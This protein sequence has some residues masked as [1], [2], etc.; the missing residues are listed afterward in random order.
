MAQICPAC[1]TSNA[2]AATTC[3]NCGAALPGLPSPRPP[4][5]RRPAPRRAPRGPAARRA[6]PHR[7]PSPKPPAAPTAQP[8]RRRA[9]APHGA[10]PRRAPARRRPPAA[11]GRDR[12]QRADQHRARPRRPAPLQHPALSGHLGRLRVLILLLT[13]GA[14]VWLGASNA[15]RIRPAAHADRAAGAVLTGTLVTVNTTKGTLQDRALRRRPGDKKHCGNFR[16]K[17]ASGYYDGKIFHRVEDW[18]VQGGATRAAAP[19]GGSGP[20]GW[21]WPHRRV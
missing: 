10:R 13:I 11:R 21:R 16:T 18:L 19:T 2:D 6:P 20:A 15:R 8:R 14:L 1:Q 4:R 3:T 7:A 17:V 9:A 12:R 5:R